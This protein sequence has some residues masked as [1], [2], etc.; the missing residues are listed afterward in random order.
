MSR[1][2]YISYQLVEHLPKHFNE[3]GSV[4]PPYFLGQISDR[5]FYF[6]VKIVQIVIARCGVGGGAF[7]DNKVFGCSERLHFCVECMF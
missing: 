2:S 3:G 1:H 7:G 4:A 5:H 6:C